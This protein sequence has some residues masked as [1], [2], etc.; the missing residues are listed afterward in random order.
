MWPEGA[1]AEENAKTAAMT[2]CGRKVSLNQHGIDFELGVCIKQK[3][4]P[5]SALP[6]QLHV[7]FSL[8]FKQLISLCSRMK[9]NNKLRSVDLFVKEGESYPLGKMMQCEG[10]KIRCLYSLFICTG[11]SNRLNN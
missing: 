4:F 6:Y 11:T 10:V 7:D 9:G 8:F 3:S 2:N 5:V 1:A